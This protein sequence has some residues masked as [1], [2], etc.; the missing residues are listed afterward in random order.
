MFK[1]LSR[2]F[3][4]KERRETSNRSSRIEKRRKQFISIAV[5]TSTAR[6]VMMNLFSAISW[7]RFKRASKTKCSSH[8]TIIVLA[9]AMD[10]TKDWST[11]SK[12]KSRRST[13]KW[14]RLA[15]RLW[16]GTKL[17]SR[18]IIAVMLIALRT[19]W[20]IRIHLK[21]NIS[22]PNSTIKNEK[23]RI[24]ANGNYLKEC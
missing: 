15:S 21:P 9:A 11:S 14:I 20:D 5:S 8:S 1:N 22:V 12:T 16:T 4:N 7:R 10:R 24:D 17:P 19:K 23:N 13:R 18:M 6:K 2:S 3:K